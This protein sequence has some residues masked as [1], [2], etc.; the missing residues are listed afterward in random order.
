[1]VVNEVKE[2]CVNDAISL[3]CMLECST[4]TRCV[5][6]L[7]HFYCYKYLDNRISVSFRSYSFIYMTE[8][9]R[10]L[11]EFKGIVD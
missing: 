3:L 5:C 11:W 4:E 9:D 10:S 7:H 2:L 8:G 1:L 6:V